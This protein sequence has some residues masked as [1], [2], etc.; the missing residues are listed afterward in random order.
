METVFIC[1]RCG[2][3]SHHQGICHNCRIQLEKMCEHCFC[4]LGNCICLSHGE[5][6][7]K[8]L[9]IKKQLQQNLT[10][11]RTAVQHR[12]SHRKKKVVKRI[13]KRKKR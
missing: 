6:H 11:K 2:Y 4:A 12:K 1:G 8:L 7:S 9:K 5:P 3:R 13:V 10:A